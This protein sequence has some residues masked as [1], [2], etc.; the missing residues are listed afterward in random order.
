[1]IGIVAGVGHVDAQRSQAPVLA[2]ALPATAPDDVVVYCPDQL[3]PALHR[4]IGDRFKQLKYPRGGD[5]T[6]VN[7]IDYRNAWSAASP[8]QFARRASALA[9]THDVWLVLSTGYHNTEAA[10]AAL[11]TSLTELRPHVEMVV[12]ADGRYYENAQLVRFSAS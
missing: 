12:A 1:V 8:L 11:E 3:G 6:M 2:A 7:W 10:C 5:A 4:L 9:G